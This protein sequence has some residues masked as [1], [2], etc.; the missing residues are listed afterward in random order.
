MGQT[1]METEDGDP[2]QVC[3]LNKNGQSVKL[4][5]PAVYLPIRWNIQLWLGTTR[6]RMFVSQRSSADDHS[7]LSPLISNYRWSCYLSNSIRRLLISHSRIGIRNIDFGGRGLSLPW[8]CVPQIHP[9]HTAHE[10]LHDLQSSSLVRLEGGEQYQ[11]LSI[12]ATK[13]LLAEWPASQVL[14]AC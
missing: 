11:W 9:W 8:G 13:L 3:L 6:S 4:Y 14:R 1:W 2:R 7:G 12:N 10:G 5:F